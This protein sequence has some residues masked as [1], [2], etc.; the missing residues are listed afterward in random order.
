M[1]VKFPKGK[2]YIEI[3]SAIKD[4]SSKGDVIVSYWSEL[5]L[6]E[7]KGARSMFNYEH[8]TVGV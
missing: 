3:A 4:P 1:T 8:Y 6:P 2:N 5:L 7:G